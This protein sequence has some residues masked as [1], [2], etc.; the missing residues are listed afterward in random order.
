MSD[1][2]LTLQCAAAAKDSNKTLA[3]DGK[4]FERKTAGSIL[5]L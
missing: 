4:D 1:G 5:S 3:T 2:S